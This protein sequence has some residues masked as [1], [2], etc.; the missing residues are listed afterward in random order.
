MKKKNKKMRADNYLDYVPSQNEKYESA[1]D[2]NGKITIYIENKGAFNKV[3]QLLFKKPKVSQI[4][5][6]EIGSFIWSLIDGKRS[7]YDISVLL[8]DRFGET[9]EPL[10]D[11]LVQYMQTMENYNFINMSK[12]D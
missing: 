3:A 9:A 7:I 10:Y 8:K 2:D 11:R 12:I 5:L 6:D 1:V 4:H